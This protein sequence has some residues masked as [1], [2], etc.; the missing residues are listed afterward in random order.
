MPLLMPRPLNR[1]GSTFHQLVQRILADVAVKARGLT[2]KIPVGDTVATLAITP[3]RKD[4]RTSLRTRDPQEA[5][6]RQAV[7][8]AY[9]EGIWEAVRKGPKRL[10]QK[11]TVALRW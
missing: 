7:A 3:T 11:Q 2:L 4:I 6:A 10:S 9:L 1:P 5:K 8:V